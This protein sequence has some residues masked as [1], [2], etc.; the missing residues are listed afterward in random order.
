MA[1]NVEEALEAV[2]LENEMDFVQQKWGRD[3]ALI[4]GVQTETGY[5]LFAGILADL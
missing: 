3:A 5:V 2:R 1:R 4:F